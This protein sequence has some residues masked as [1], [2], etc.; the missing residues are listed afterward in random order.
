[1][2][3]ARSALL[4]APSFARSFAL[5]TALALGATCGGLCTGCAGDPDLDAALRNQ[6]EALSAPRWVLVAMDGVELADFEGG[7]IDLQL[8]AD[9]RVHGNAGVN[10]YSG[11]WRAT[12]AGELRVGTLAT[13][14]RL[15]PSD[16]MQREKRFLDLLARTEGC[17]LEGE[18]LTLRDR[19]GAASLVF[20][21]AA[22]RA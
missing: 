18:S 13:T 8:E 17:V 21:R 3:H 19:D 4:R 9:G 10:R 7:P 15:G 22:R 5:S 1:M 16:L 11:P 12:R 20:E 2:P 6:R 14:R